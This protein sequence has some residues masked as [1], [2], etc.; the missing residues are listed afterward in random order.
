ME[1]LLHERRLKLHCTRWLGA[2]SGLAV[3]VTAGPQ[4]LQSLERGACSSIHIGH[5]SYF[6]RFFVHKYGFSLQT[7]VQKWALYEVQVF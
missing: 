4:T 5:L 1:Q 2:G 7:L 3:G 6:S